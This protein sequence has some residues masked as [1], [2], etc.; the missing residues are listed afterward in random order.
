[1]EI[2]QKATS[3]AQIQAEVDE[4]WTQGCAIKNK[5]LVF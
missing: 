3:T 2:A 5:M 1:M 4:V